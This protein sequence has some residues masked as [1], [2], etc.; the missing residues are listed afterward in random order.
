MRKYIKAKGLESVTAITLTRSLSSVLG[1]YGLSEWDNVFPYP[2]D[3]HIKNSVE[4]PV[5]L[6]KGYK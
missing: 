2:Q 6:W 3:I 1:A 4:L 5:L